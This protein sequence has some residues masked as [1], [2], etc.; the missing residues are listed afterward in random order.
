[1]FLLSF[2]LIG[3]L[4]TSI[5]QTSEKVEDV[6]E[7][8][9]ENGPKIEFESKVVDYGTIENG[10]DGNREFTFTNTGNEP[11]IISNAKG[12][13][14]CTVPTWPRTP[15]A[16]GESS[17]IKVRYATNRTGGFSKTVTLT[18]NAVNES[19][20]VLKI[21]GTVLPKPTEENKN[22]EIH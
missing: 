3:M 5:A 8:T 12:S 13:C 9:N 19:R 20:V 11:L 1:M 7:A 17:V 2:A 4:T 14:G 6:K 15:I 18:T 10:A 16:P 22:E 21:K